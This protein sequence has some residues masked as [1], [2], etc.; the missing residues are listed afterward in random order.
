LTTTAAGDRI[1]HK[2]DATVDDPHDHL[3]AD[4]VA[5]RE[6]AAGLKAIA[7]SPAAGSSTAAL[8]SA[9]AP[10]GAG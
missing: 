1:R 4:A 3:V 9:Q 8:P 5:R 6:A 10:V 2:G 7:G